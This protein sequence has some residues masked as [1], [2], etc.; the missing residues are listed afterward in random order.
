MLCKK[1][2]EREIQMKITSHTHN[3]GAHN[4]EQNEMTVGMDLAKQEL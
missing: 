3:T 1:N 2:F 4:S